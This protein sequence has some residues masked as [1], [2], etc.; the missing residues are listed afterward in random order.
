MQGENRCVKPI[1]MTNTVGITSAPP[2]PW[3]CEKV[4]RVDGVGCDPIF[5]VQRSLTARLNPKLL[6]LYT[7]KTVQRLGPESV[8]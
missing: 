5:S 7:V 3:K 1:L 2:F 4:S 6:P 8:A